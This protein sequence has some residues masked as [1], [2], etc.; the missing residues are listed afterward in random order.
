MTP[1]KL[2]DIREK[3]QIEAG[4]ILGIKDVF[5]LNYTDT[6][7]F[8]DHK[9]REDIAKIIKKT[10]PNII[11]TWDP[12]FF[13]SKSFNMINHTDHRAAG[14]ATMDACYPLA[15][16]RLIYPE[17]ENE[18]LTPHS[19]EEIWFMGSDEPSLLIDVTQTFEKKLKA[20]FK[21]ESQFENFEK[22]K[23]KVKE[24]GSYFGKKKGYKYAENFIRI[25]IS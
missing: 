10:K 2:S 11:I 1:K 21:H 13:Y 3:E 23:E 5:F 14:V 4:K 17:H 18:G 12:N 16:D 15:R 9:L 25:K 24:W 22:I 19:C 6:Q 8:A 7:L 20:L